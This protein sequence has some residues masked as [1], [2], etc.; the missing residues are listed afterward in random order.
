[1]KPAGTVRRRELNEDMAEG[2]HTS[3]VTEGESRL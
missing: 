1:M 2:E 3:V